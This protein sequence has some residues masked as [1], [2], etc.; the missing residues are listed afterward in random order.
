MLYASAKSVREERSKHRYALQ[1][2]S[3][4]RVTLVRGKSGW[5]VTGAEAICNY[6]SV[7]T[8]R[9][10]RALVRDVVKLVTRLVRGEEAHPE[11]FDETVECLTEFK[12]G[13]EQV[14][15][16]LYSLRILHALG[17]LAP[18]ESFGEILDSR[19]IYKDSRMYTSN[20]H[21]E[22]KRHINEALHQSQL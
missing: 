7:Q 18:A 6:Y 13:L 19:G 4:V 11:L 12:T 2:C 20:D 22:W 14:T 15:L 16:L 1:E 17:Y 3:R 8:T 5:K 9:E 10:G 21:A